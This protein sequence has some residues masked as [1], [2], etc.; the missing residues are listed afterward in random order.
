MPV[1]AIGAAYLATTGAAA[2]VAA[3]GWTLMSILSTVAAVGS[4]VSAVGVLTH[5]AGLTK[6]GA[7][8][9]GV[10]AV[11]ALATGAG[12][13]G[14][15]AKTDVL[16]G[17]APVTAASEAAA[18]TAVSAGGLTSAVTDPAVAIE[19]AATAPPVGAAAPLVGA[20]APPATVAAES[21]VAPS[22]LN[23][24]APAVTGVAEAPLVTG[25]EIRSTISSL[26]GPG[27][28]MVSSVADPA[29]AAAAATKAAAAQKSLDVMTIGE[30]GGSGGGSF[31]KILTWMEKNDKLA[32][33]GIQAAGTFLQEEM[34][35]AEAA[36]VN[37]AKA[38]ADKLAAETND[39]ARLNANAAAPLPTVRV[40]RKKPGLLNGNTLPINY[41]N[42]NINYGVRA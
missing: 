2:L 31:G 10:G 41:G 42:P 9:G 16:F 1:I 26:V 37:L 17:A 33:G 23:S 27:A 38:Q 34:T 25:E 3:E 22:L 11:G 39:V 5:D 12:L 32:L 30:D 28:P 35:G 29:A 14:A 20:A 13:F 18:E 7:I 21:A 8:V 4:V 24:A 6:W 19:A 36:K 15:A 40:K